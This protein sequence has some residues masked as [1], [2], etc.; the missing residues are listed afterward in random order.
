MKFRSFSLLIKALPIWLA[1]G[2]SQGLAQTYTWSN[3]VIPAGGFVAGVDYSPVSQG[4]IYARTDIGGFYRWDS[5]TN[6]WIP[7]ADMFGSSQ[8]NNY[9][10]ESIA[11]DPVNANNVYVAAG[12]YEWNGNGVILSSTNQGNTWTVNPIAVPMGG[13]YDGRIA[14]ER[15]AVDPNS[16]NILYFASR[17]N[18]LWKSTNSA[19]S[20][21]NV[22]SFPVTGD[23]PYGL[24]Y[25]IFLPGGNPGAGAETIFVGVDTLSAGNSSLYYST[26]AGGTWAV[27]PG[28]PTNMI[29]PHASLGTD[30]N[31]WVVYDSG[32]YGPN[33]ISNGEVW[34]LNT[35]T[36]SWTQLTPG[37]GNVGF[38]GIC[39]DPENAQHVV[40]ATIDWW[41]GPD[42][43][44]STTNGGTS[45]SVIGN[46]QTS[47]DGYAAPFANYVNN[48]AIW[49]MFCSAYN[50]GTGWQGD[51]KIDPYNSNNAIYTTGGGVWTSTNIN[52]A[53][54]PAGV[55]WTFTDY[56]LEETSVLDMTA[57]AEGGTFFSAVRDIAGMRHTNLTQ[58]PAVGMY[59]NPEFTDTTGIDYAESAPNTVVRVG[60][61]GAIAS[62]GAYSTNNGQ[63]W[64]P[65]A[66]VP[67]NADNEMQS[68]AISA[69]GL[70]ILAVPNNGDG[71]PSYS[72]N[73]GSSW[74]ACTGL[75]GGAQ[76]CSDRVDSNIFYGVSGTTLYVSTNGGSSFASAGTYAGTE[77]GRPRAVFGIAGEVWVPTSSGLYRFTNVGLGT[78]ATKIITN[79]SN[80]VAVGFGMADSPTYTHPAVY[81][82][83][84]IS[85]NYGFFRCDDGV[86]TTWT[87]INNSNQLFGAVGFAAGDESVYGRMY[88]GTNG[89]GILYGSVSISSTST[90]TPSLTNTP[91]R[92]NTP[93]AT[94]TYSGT[95]TRTMTTT[96]TPT[97]TLT[98][99]RTNTVTS[100]QTAT[101]TVTPTVTSTVTTTTTRT[102]TPTITS[103][104]TSA[105]TSTVTVSST[106]TLTRTST[107]TATPT[108]TSTTTRTNTATVT[109]TS[110][111][112]VT[113][114]MT[115]QY[116]PT[117]TAT[118]TSSATLTSTFTATPTHTLT[119]T[120]TVT[121]TIT[122]TRT[123]TTTRTNTTT[124]TPTQTS[125][126]TLTLTETPTATLEFSATNTL[127]P[128]ATMSPT[129]TVTSTHTLTVTT[130]STETNTATA[131]TTATATHTS[132]VT[133]TTTTT[134]TST[135]TATYQFSPTNTLSPTSTLTYTTTVTTPQTGTNTNTPTSTNNSTQTSTPTQS[136]SPTSTFSPTST[137][138]P[139]PTYTPTCGMTTWNPPPPPPLFLSD[140]R[141]SGV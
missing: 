122:P 79:V 98:M 127:S 104:S 19:A 27:V 123:S 85:G 83:G 110:T 64:T 48:G 24:S 42:H 82:V 107:S 108:Q 54:Q 71:N 41:G 5:S 58:S 6:L 9:G 131:T 126:T 92:T 97:M 136:L 13:N 60:Y 129:I 141:A 111:L 53:T 1:L 33:N 47:F 66:S 70:T 15:L 56:G 44:Y 43:I 65:M 80:A 135:T 4:L 67:E 61:G 52:A 21:N 118:V 96:S 39:V 114:T 46:A 69:N 68:V 62:D 115:S 105:N 133:A 7:L 86:G 59:C 75:P 132:T 16:N 74:T 20:W 3:V 124:I 102:A 100:T 72:G 78:V 10:G 57:S 139:T 14:G 125:T 22:A 88:I 18:G 32:G 120:P 30:G 90:P 12:M 89:R 138:T 134:P 28:G 117:I 38:G 50:G 17:N 137:Y 40:V 106:P 101:P 36:L 140:P 49:T 34:K 91:T 103:T 2:C 87:Q 63:T 76:I 119:F 55:T 116:T 45:W 26:N 31:L 121:F 51:I 8:Y 113:S 84:T 73:F 23:S 11:P 99:T 25:V 95:P 29:T 109:T 37:P 130:T 81:L 35:R 77:S 112:T 128:T 93:V 94:A